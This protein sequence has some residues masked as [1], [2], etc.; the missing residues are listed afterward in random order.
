[1][2]HIVPDFDRSLHLG[3]LMCICYLENFPT[4]A[5]YFHSFL[6]F[7]LIALHTFLAFTL[8]CLILKYH[9][10]QIVTLNETAY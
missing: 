4:F 8:C 1:M 10:L 2:L 6:T 9:T 5:L 3:C 7:T